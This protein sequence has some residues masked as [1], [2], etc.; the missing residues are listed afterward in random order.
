[1]EDFQKINDMMI[2]GRYSLI[3]RTFLVHLT[4]VF[5]HLSDKR[6]FVDL[7]SSFDDVFQ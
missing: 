3:L 5:I 4:F 1:M 6:N 2:M 7:F